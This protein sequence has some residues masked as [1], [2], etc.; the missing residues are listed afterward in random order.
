MNLVTSSNVI[1]ISIRTD[2]SKE[3]QSPKT[4]MMFIGKV[5]LPKIENVAHGITLGDKVRIVIEN[6]GKKEAVYATVSKIT[7]KKSDSFM[8]ANL[9]KV[10]E[11]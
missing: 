4:L 9:S 7:S 10:K 1:H 6:S 3:K 8:K 11:K 5:E 2:T